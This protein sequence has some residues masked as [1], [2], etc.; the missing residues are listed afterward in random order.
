MSADFIAVYT[1]QAVKFVLPV[2]FLTKFDTSQSSLGRC[3]RVTQY[4][5]LT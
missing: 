4:A 1:L 3:Q 5:M 2:Y